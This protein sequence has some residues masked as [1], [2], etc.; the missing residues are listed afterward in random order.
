MVSGQWSVVGAWFCCS[1][2]WQP[3]LQEALT[4]S[5]PTL[6]TG[7]L[8]TGGLPA[9]IQM[10]TKQISVPRTISPVVPSMCHPTVICRCQAE[11]Q[12]NGVNQ[13]PWIQGLGLRKWDSCSSTEGFGG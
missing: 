10:R 11:L 6:L 8:G 7:E 13:W 12:I 3:G 9:C 2:G 5:S 1:T 4:M